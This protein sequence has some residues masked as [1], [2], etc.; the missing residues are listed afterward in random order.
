MQKYFIEID[1]D[2]HKRIK[3]RNIGFRPNTTKHTEPIEIILK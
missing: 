3:T 2:K 1:Y